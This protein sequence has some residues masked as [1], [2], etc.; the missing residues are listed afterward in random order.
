MNVRSYL[1]FSSSHPSPELPIPTT[2]LSWTWITRAQPAVRAHTKSI[3]W[4]QHWWIL[5]VQVL[6][7]QIIDVTFQ[8]LTFQL[9]HRDGNSDQEE[10]KVAPLDSPSC[11]P[12]WVL[13]CRGLPVS[14]RSKMKVMFTLGELDGFCRCLL[15]TLA[16]IVF[17]WRACAD[18][19]SRDRMIPIWRCHDGNFSILHWQNGLYLLFCAPSTTIFTWKRQVW[20]QSIQKWC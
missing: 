2:Q 18:A 6:T 20:T 13:S 19:W 5:Q 7:S 17:F 1:F 3:S 12:T 9:H 4:T 14:A 10:V 15:R 8:I 16:F 11:P